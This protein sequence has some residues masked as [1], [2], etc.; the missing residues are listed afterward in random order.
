ML[1]EQVTSII[2]QT[3]GHDP[4]KCPAQ[5]CQCLK[6]AIKIV[7]LL[8]QVHADDRNRLSEMLDRRTTELQRLQRLVGEEA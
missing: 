4:S 8:Q 2:A 5:G 6:A 1:I 3:R 7:S